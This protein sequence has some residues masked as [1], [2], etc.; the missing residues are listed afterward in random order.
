MAQTFILASYCL[1]Y[2]VICLS[3]YEVKAS[4]EIER[5]KHDTFQ[6]LRCR[7]SQSCKRDHCQAYSAECADNKCERCRCSKNG[8]NTFVTSGANTG[9][10]TKDESVILESSKNRY[11]DNIYLICRRVRL[12]LLTSKYTI[13]KY[14]IY[15][16][17]RQAKG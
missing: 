11:Y 14:A 17:F 13:S 10:C 12:I 15:V 6:N 4:F 7:T 1:G 8:R 5:G 2:L 9:N 3:G 16:N